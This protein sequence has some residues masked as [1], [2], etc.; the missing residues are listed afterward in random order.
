MG[1][2]L[3]RFSSRCSTFSLRESFESINTFQTNN[4]LIWVTDPELKLTISGTNSCS[5]PAAGCST[6]TGGRRSLFWDAQTHFSTL[7]DNISHSHAACCM[8]HTQYS[9]SLALRLL[10]IVLYVKGSLLISYSSVHFHYPYNLGPISG[11]YK[12]RCAPLRCRTA[13]DR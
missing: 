1:I 3:L 6:H 4:S 8:Y 12:K 5:G 13:T 9:L 7:T 2:S 11:E 10:S